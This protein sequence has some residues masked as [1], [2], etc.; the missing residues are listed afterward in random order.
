MLLRLDNVCLIYIHDVYLSYH[1]YILVCLLICIFQLA[2]R[3]LP[4]CLLIDFCN[5]TRHDNKVNIAT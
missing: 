4:D 2:P 1:G 5:K 3:V